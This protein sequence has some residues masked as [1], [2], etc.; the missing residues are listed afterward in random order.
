MT[1]KVTI[2]IAIILSALVFCGC[3]NKE[4]FPAEGVSSD[5][6]EASVTLDITS[7]KPAAKETEVTKKEIKPLSPNSRQA[8]FQ[9]EEFSVAVELM[10]L[11]SS[12]YYPDIL[13]DYGINPEMFVVTAAVTVKNLTDEEKDFDGTKFTLSDMFSYGGDSEGFK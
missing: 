12:L 2:P 13:K 7:A 6:P 4:N 11:Q 3:E 1:R 5:I 8:Y 9:T 10:E